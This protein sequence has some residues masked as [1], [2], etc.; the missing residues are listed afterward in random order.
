MKKVTT[1]ILLLYMGWCY[2]QEDGCISNFAEFGNSV[3]ESIS[4]LLIAMQYCTRT[5]FP[6]R[7]MQEANTVYIRTYVTNY[8][9]IG[10]K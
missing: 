8:Y 7:H 9:Y 3:Y 2:E 6:A 10:I 1:C 5:Y 4:K